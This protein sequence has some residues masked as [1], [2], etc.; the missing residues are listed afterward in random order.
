MHVFDVRERIDANAMAVLHKLQ[1][2]GPWVVEGEEPVSQS[3]EP[4]RYAENLDDCDIR[5]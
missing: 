1:G 2:R 3:V 5:Q 4:S